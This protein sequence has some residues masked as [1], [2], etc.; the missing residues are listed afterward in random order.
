MKHPLSFLVTLAWIS[1]LMPTASFAEDADRVSPHLP[2][3]N[4][5]GVRLPDVTIESAR[6]YDAGNNK[7][8]VNHLQLL[9]TIGGK[10]GFELLL[11]DA[12]NGRFVMG[13]GGLFWDP[14][15]NQARYELRGQLEAREQIQRP[16][17]PGPKLLKPPHVRRC[18]CG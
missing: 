1:V 3:Q 4:L 17:Q 14:S 9:G 18:W 15:H 6:H 11:P 8:K 7:A 5:K 12:W 2:V 16:V 13:G 10:I